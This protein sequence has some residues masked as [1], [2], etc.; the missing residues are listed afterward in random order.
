VAAPL[1]FKSEPKLWTNTP[2]GFVSFN[3]GFVDKVGPNGGRVIIDKLIAHGSFNVDVTTA[4]LKG[5]NVPRFMRL[6]TV[7]MKDGTLRYNEVPGDC[8]R[9]ALFEMIGADQVKEH[10]DIATGAGQT[11][12]VTLPLPLAKPFAHEGG[13][14]SM[15]AE[16]GQEIRISCASAAELSGL[17]TSVVAINSG[18]YWIVA[19][20]HEEMDVVQH[21]IDEI[22]VQD[23]ESTAAQEARLVTNGRLHDL[24]LMVRGDSGGGS[25][26]NLT[27]AWI[28]SP[29]NVAPQLLV[30][31]D[32][33]EHYARERKQTSGS[34]ST[35]GAYLRSDP[36][37]GATIRACA[38]LICTD[39][40]AFEQPERETVNVKTTQTGGGPGLITMIARIAKPRLDSTKNEVAA[41][42]GLKGQYRVK[43]ASNTMRHPS[44][45]KE[46]H[47]RYMP[48]KFT[49]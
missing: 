5:Q 36:F 40:K 18:S 47:L 48:I 14:Y 4:A 10:A 20:C 1:K 17:S 11:V 24:L 2:G 22:K 32:L 28:S 38:V 8:V 35:Q 31:P 27:E 43:T 16:L 21:A 13:D 6:N 30:Q 23:F 7:K 25:L 49:G 41:K 26:A 39:T 12:L 37:V 34:A 44:A 9:T 33:V 45:W 15:A 3:F 29:I 46:E 19:E 42:Y